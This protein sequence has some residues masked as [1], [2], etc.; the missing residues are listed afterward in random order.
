MSDIIE[1]AECHRQEAAPG[2]IWPKS[3]W[4]CLCGS[5]AVDSW[6]CAEKF[7]GRPVGD[8]EMDYAGDDK[9]PA[10]RSSQ[11]GQGEGTP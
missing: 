9:E 6:E 8:E 10:R 5:I 4:W 1:C 3:G 7:L 2:N 11:G